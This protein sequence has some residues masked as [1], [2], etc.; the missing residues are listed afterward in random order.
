MAQ[1]LCDRV[2]IIRKGRLLANQPLSELLD[3]F[4]HEHYQ[5]R[6]KGGIESYHASRFAGLTMDTE[7]G[8]TILSGAIADQATLHQHLAKVYDLQLPLLSVTRIEPNLEE[9]FMQLLNEGEKG[10]QHENRIVS[11]VQ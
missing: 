1:E 5:I 8:D 3:L 4:C 2:A 7:N 10:E 11:Y 6:I 9:V